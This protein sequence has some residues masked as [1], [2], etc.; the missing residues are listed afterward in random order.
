MR[1]FVARRRR[2][3][4]R[5][6]ELPFRGR[7]SR[8]GRHRPLPQAAGRDM[9]A[10]RALRLLPLLAAAATV[11]LEPAAAVWPQPQVEGYPPGGGRCSLPPRRFR[12]AY[13]AGS[14]VG[15]GCAVLEAAFQ[16]YWALL[17]AAARPTGEAGRG[18]PAGRGALRPAGRAVESFTCGFILF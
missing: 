14:A 8:G 5:G 9:A 3:R 2:A 10:G 17:F 15:P 1:A 11:V 4:P 16:R 13:A 12:F 18:L 6:A 7:P